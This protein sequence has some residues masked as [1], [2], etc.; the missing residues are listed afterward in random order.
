MRASFNIDS[1]TGQ[2][3]TKASL[4]FETKN[5][6]AVTLTVSDGLATDTIAVT[7]NVTDVHENHPHPCSQKVRAPL[8]LLLKILKQVLISGMLSPLPIKMQKIL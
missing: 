7:I 5:N 2:I 4:D 1:Q 6:Y 8:E 3:K